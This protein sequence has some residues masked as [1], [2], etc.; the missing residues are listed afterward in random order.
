M[1][2]RAFI[3]KDNL[4]FTYST[5]FTEIGNTLYSK[6][7]LSILNLVTNE[8]KIF[9]DGCGSGKCMLSTGGVYNLNDRYMIW[10][11]YSN[12]YIFDKC[13]TYQDYISVHNH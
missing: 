10:K 9:S 13:P 11:H 5:D 4:I 8:K 2:G 6:K 12:Y 7:H 3:D 1:T